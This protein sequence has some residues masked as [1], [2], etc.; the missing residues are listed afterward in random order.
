MPT[1]NS[2][3]FLV[4]KIS[5]DFSVYSILYYFGG[6]VEYKNMMQKLTLKNCLGVAL[7]QL[8]KIGIHHLSTDSI[9]EYKK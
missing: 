2:F 4:K 3:L 6:T 8:S 7:H 9:K 5:L 1:T